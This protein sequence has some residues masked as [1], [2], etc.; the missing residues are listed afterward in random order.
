V[1]LIKDPQAPTAGREEWP[2]LAATPIYS[3]IF[4]YIKIFFISVAGHQA[5]RPPGH[6]ATHGQSWPVLLSQLAHCYALVKTS[7]RGPPKAGALALTA[8]LDPVGMDEGHVGDPAPLPHEPRAGPQGA[9]RF[10]TGLALGLGRRDEAGRRLRCARTAF[11]C[12]LGM[13]SWR[14]ASASCSYRR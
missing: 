6:Q 9:A 11:R 7:T 12:E 8:P 2:V 13:E 10:H 14:L 1:S 4:R 3:D 5:T